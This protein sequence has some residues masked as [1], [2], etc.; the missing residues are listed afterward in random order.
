MKTVL[1]NSLFV[2]FFIMGFGLFAAAQA[3]PQNS[4]ICDNPD[5]PVKWEKYAEF[6]VKNVKYPQAAIDSKV[7]GLAKIQCVIDIDGTASDFKIISTELHPSLNEEALRVAKIMPKLT[8]ATK[9]GKPV[10][11]LYILAVPF[12]YR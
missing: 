6:L 5:T 9:A 8:P 11:A 7:G 3:N 1:K 12:R 4:I 2:I 10:R